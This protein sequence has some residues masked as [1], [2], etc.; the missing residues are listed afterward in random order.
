MDKATDRICTLFGGLDMSSWVEMK[1]YEDQ[2]SA[3]L[4]ADASVDAPVVN[5]PTFRT[6]VATATV[7]AAS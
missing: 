7:F 5:G 6:S 4:F 3:K 1:K 2:S